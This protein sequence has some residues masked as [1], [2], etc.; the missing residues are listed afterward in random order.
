VLR[1]SLESAHLIAGP[2]LIRA[3]IGKRLAQIRTA[4]PATAQRKRLDDALAK[5]TSAITRLIGAYQE[6]LL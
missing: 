3:E 5:T 1:R 4:D 6:D 2:A